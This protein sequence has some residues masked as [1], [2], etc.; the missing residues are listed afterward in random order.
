MNKTISLLILTFLLL[1]AVPAKAQTRNKLYVEYINKYSSLAVEEMH[2]YK[3][4]ASITLAQGILESGAGQSRLARKGNNH[5]GIKCGGDWTGPTIREHD[6]ARNECFRKYK[7]ALHSYEDH[8]RFLAQRPRYKDLFK[9]SV[10]DY[11]GWAHGLRKAGYATDPKYATR[12]INIIETYDLH[13]YDKAGKRS[14]S[15]KNTP[16]VTNPHQL[17]LANDLVFV[18]VRQGDTFKSISQ[19]LGISQSKL[20]KYND[21]HK[22][23]VL[24]PGERIFLKKKKTKAAKGQDMHLVR[25]NDSMHSIS[26]QYGIRLKNL[27]KM[28]KKTADYHPAIG[29]RIRLR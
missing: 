23:Y 22:K 28:N 29:D 15:S 6:D 9:L 13:K 26:Q 18:V 10:T 20:I 12:L 16:T 11:K 17:Y 25:G 2:K 8:S 4:P 21:L 19:E 27:Y 1:A 14:S 3:I 5:F 24:Q 7:S